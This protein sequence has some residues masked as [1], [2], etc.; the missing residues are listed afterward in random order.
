[1]SKPT[2]VS[3]KELYS[4]SKI[5]DNLILAQKLTIEVEKKL[6]SEHKIRKLSRKQK[7]IAEDISELIVANEN[8]ED[9]MKSIP[10]YVKEPCDKNQKKIKEVESVALDHQIDMYLASILTASKKL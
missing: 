10:S 3:A 7:Q 8:P 6:R 5:K 4:L 1:M 2:K 9:W